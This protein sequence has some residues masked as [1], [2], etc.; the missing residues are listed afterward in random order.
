MLHI[1]CVSLN[2]D[3]PHQTSTSGTRWLS[4]WAHPHQSSWRS[5]SPQWGTMSKTGQSMQDSLFPSSSPTAFSLLT[6]STTNSKVRTWT[7]WMN[8]IS[9]ILWDCSD[10]FVDYHHACNYPLTIC[11]PFHRLFKFKTFACLCIKTD[12]H[13]NVPVLWF[14]SVELCSISRMISQKKW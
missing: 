6:L 5:F 10:V 8:C 14:C 3:P 13:A 4:S 1:P 12:T 9:A 11:P 7:V 2:P